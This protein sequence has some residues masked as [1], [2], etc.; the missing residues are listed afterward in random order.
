MKFLKRVVIGWLAV[1]VAAVVAAFTVKKTV[2]AFGDESDDS[3][4]LVATI[5]GREFAS[6]AQHFVHGSALAVMGG[7]DLDLS[8][9]ALAPGAKLELRAFMGGIDVSVPRSWR[10]EVISTE[11]MGEVVNLLDEDDQDDEGPLL[12]VYA[13]ATMGGISISPAYDS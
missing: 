5:G 7:V 6:S 1:V 10:V 3:F 9:A 13:T 2:P 11:R 8:T 4:S 12:I